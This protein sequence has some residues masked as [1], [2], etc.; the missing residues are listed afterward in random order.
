LGSGNKP[1]LDFLWN[2]RSCPLPKIVENIRFSI[3]TVINIIIITTII[4][5]KDYI[6]LPVLSLKKTIHPTLGW[7]TLI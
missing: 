5:F 4:R 2:F 3:I 7:P 6:F 1:R